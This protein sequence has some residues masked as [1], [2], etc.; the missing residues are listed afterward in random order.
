MK[1]R[2]LGLLQKIVEIFRHFGWFTLLLIPIFFFINW[3]F[4]ATVS[5]QK[6]AIV[7]GQESIANQELNNIDFF[8]NAQLASVHNDIHVILDANE[9]MAYIE[10]PNQSN[11]TEMRNLVYRILLNKQEFIN[12]SVFDID[13]NEL[14]KISRNDGDLVI[15]EDAS[16]DN[17]A[18]YDYF[19][20]ITNLE[21]QV[22]FIDQLRIVDNHPLLSLIAP[23][24]DGENLEYFIK[25]DYDADHFLS[26]FELYTGNLSQDFSLGFVNMNNLWLIN[27]NTNSLYLVND[28]NLYQE[29]KNDNEYFLEKTINLEDEHRHYVSLSE[30]FF[31]AYIVID[32][33]DI[34]SDSKSYALRFSWII[35]LINIL[36]IG[37]ISYVAYII[38]AKSDDRILL[39]ANMYLSNKNT[40]AVVITEKDYSI[41]YVNEAFERYFGYTMD[42]VIGKRPRDVIGQIGLKLDYDNYDFKVYEGNLWN[43][44]KDDIKLYKYLSVRKE[45]SSTGKTKH[46][47]GLYSEPQIFIDDYY[48][49]M[50]NK[51]DIIEGLTTIFTN[52][53]FIKEQ[54]FLFLI[55]VDNCDIHDLSKFI[56]VRLDKR[57]IVC[58]P[59]SN[60]ILIYLHAEMIELKS[61]MDHFDHILQV[62]KHLTSTDRSFTHTLLSAKADESIDSIEELMEALFVVYQLSKTNPH[63]KYHIYTPEMKSIIHRDKQIFEALEKAF[64]N[65][66]FYMCYQVQQNLENKNYVGAEALLRWKNENL[67]QVRPDEF[68]PI[69]ENSLFINQLSISVLD[70]VIKDFEPYLDIIPVDFRISVN[71]TNF[72]LNSDSIIDQLLNMI[73][74]SILPN[75]F[76]SFE[77]T[78]SNYVDNIE[79]ANRVIEKFHDKDIILA[80]DDFGTGYSSINSLKSID[81]DQ[82]KIDRNFIFNYPEDDDG[83]MFKIIATL[84]H[85]LNKTIIVEGTETEEQVNFCKENHCHMAQGY[86]QSK[87]IPINNFVKQ[88][89]K[90][91]IGE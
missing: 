74:H 11:L 57:Y 69:I 7:S 48:K 19:S 54:T 32:M 10:N 61:L 71:L 58:I 25:I 30:N 78:E 85:S 66:E 53:P 1:N 72:D 42:E 82:V 46:Y 6:T 55:R 65:G 5:A 34:I 18:S 87:P 80:I 8:I 39:N 20:T 9:T 84:I 89:L 56:K 31:K 52:Q 43:K 36:A 86:F 13:G 38:K 51:S 75:T 90:N 63:L 27:Q 15:V 3:S 88:F 91:K 16:L 68:I 49:Y 73:D 62:Y 64:L 76:F 21:N 12:S 41:Y 81:I 29:S 70:M 37:F 67:G 45:A 77:I 60:F 44:T 14:F 59:K 79:K 40:D 47:I 83:S 50:E 23:V 4:F 28:G 24:F 33:D 17:I 35:I 26:I 22:L 2:K